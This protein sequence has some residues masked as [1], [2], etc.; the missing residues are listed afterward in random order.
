MAEYEYTTGAVNTHC[1]VTVDFAINRYNVSATAGAGGILSGSTPSPAVKDYNTTHTFTFNADT[2]YHIV[3]V[4]GCG[5][6]TFSPDYVVGTG[7]VTTV[8]YTTGPITGDCTVAA[9]FAVSRYNVSA[10][11]GVW[12]SLSG[13]RRHR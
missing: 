7:G 8:N 1:T 2:G 9:I 3:S 12:G 6:T 5:G 13:P 4:S 11:A 10:T